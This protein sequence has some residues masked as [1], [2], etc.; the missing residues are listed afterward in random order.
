MDGGFHGNGNGL[1]ILEVIMTENGVD[2]RTLGEVDAL[3]DRLSRRAWRF[4]F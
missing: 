2:I 1:Q 3:L 4:R